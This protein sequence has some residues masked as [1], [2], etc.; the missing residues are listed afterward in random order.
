MKLAA[1]DR[2]GAT[3]ASLHVAADGGFVVVDELAAAGAESQLTGLHDVR[4]LFERGPASLSAFNAG[5]V[6]AGCVEI[7]PSAIRRDRGRRS[8]S[9]FGCEPHAAN[10][11]W[12]WYPV[13]GGGSRCPPRLPGCHRD[14]SNRVDRRCRHRS[15]PAPSA[16]RWAHNST[17]HSSQNVQAHLAITGLSPS[18]GSTSGNTPVTIYGTGFL[19]GSSVDSAPH[20]ESMPIHIGY[21]NNCCKPCRQQLGIRDRHQPVATDCPGFVHLHGRRPASGVVRQPDQ[22]TCHGRPEG[23]NHRLR[24]LQ[25]A[26]PSASAAGRRPLP[27]WS[28]PL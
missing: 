20:P 9:R 2:Q 25:R 17:T 22:R 28:R 15:Y 18:T 14:P 23:N 12:T 13:G 21:R 27:G 24:I 5:A 19:Y 16:L 3:T 6:A 4:H 1:L 26:D 7:P 11:L 10:A 8:E